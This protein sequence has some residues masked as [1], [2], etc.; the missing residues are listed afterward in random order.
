MRKKEKRK[1]KKWNLLLASSWADSA[2]IDIICRK[3]FVE[4]ILGGQ[5]K[6][7]SRPSAEQDFLDEKLKLS[8][9]IA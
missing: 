9:R 7:A 1:K 8:G 2:V 6:F 4:I 5:D 3:S